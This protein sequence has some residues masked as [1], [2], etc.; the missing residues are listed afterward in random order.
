MGLPATLQ[1]SALK[2][3]KFLFCTSI[4]AGVWSPLGCKRGVRGMWVGWR[5]GLF[6]WEFR[7][8]LNR[9]PAA[10]ELQEEKE[11]WLMLC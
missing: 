10:G 4:S 1:G 2:T 7:R 8:V 5:R 9:V 11:S 6:R 3:G